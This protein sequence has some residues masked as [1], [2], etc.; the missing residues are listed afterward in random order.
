[1]AI[2]NSTAFSKEQTGALAESVTGIINAL[3]NT[4]QTE[5]QPI[6]NQIKGEDIIGESETKEPLMATVAQVEQ[7]MS[8][9][10]DKLER[11]QKAI[12]AVCET[13]GVA[14]NKNITSTDEAA[15]TVAAA[16]KKVEESTGKNA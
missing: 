4:F 9:V 16:K 1:M 15:Q 13:T 7:T 8:V 12:T 10:T 14:I 6:I 2:K 3:T 11:M 5:V